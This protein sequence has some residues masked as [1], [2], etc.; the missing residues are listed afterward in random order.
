MLR[1]HWNY[2]LGQRLDWLRRTRCQ[3]D[4]CS[5]VSEAIGE[6]PERVNYY[7]QS[8]TLKETKQLFPEYKD[9]YAEVQQ[10]NLIRLDKAWQRWM[11]PNATGKRGGRPCFKKKGELRSFTFP[12][13]NCFKA[14]AHLKNNVLKLSKIGEIG[15][16]VHRQLLAGFTLK[17]ATIIRKPDGWYVA[18]SM[19]DKTVPET[20]PIE[21]V[22]N[23]VGIDVGVKVFLA[24]SKSETVDA[25]KFYRRTQAHLARQQRF[26]ARQTKGSKNSQKQANKIARIH[27]KIA[28]QRQDFHYNTAYKL[29][30]EYDLIAVEDLNIRGLARTRLAKSILDCAWGNFLKILEAVAVKRGNWFVKVNAHGTSQIC[31]RCGV[32]VPKTLSVRLHSCH[33]CQLEMDRDENA[34]LNVLHRALNTV[35][36]MVSACRGQ[37]VAQPVKQEAWTGLVGTQL[38]LF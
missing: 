21:Q 11:I 17:T 32:K 12:R 6:I 19:E 28:R 31:S 29:N 18:V 10:Q 25:P 3:I 26:L 22:K 38:S 4:R 14:G 20:I 5:I 15:I 36:L 16:I 2:A 30:K 24:T 13:I 1:Q 33:H 34:A 23:P 9:I 37:E 8:A 27:Q 7:T 35:G